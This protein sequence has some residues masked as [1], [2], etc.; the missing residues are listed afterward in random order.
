MENIH[1]Y[2]K[3]NQKIDTFILY[4]ISYEKSTARPN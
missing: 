3:Y 4:G 1:T 2:T